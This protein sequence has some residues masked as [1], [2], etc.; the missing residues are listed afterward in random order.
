MREAI[1]GMRPERQSPNSAAAQ[2]GIRSLED[3]EK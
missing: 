3:E 2:S 1:S